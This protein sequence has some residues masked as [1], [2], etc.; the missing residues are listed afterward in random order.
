[1]PPAA[2][3]G[4]GPNFSVRNWMISGS[5]DSTWRLSSTPGA[6]ALTT[7]MPPGSS[8]RSNDHRSMPMVVR[9]VA[10]RVGSVQW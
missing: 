9:Y 3:C 7:G 1:M 5:R 4:Y 6:Y 2:L 10:M 8:E